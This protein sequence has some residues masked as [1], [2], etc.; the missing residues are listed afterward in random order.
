MLSADWAAALASVIDVATTNIENASLAVSTVLPIPP[1]HTSAVA[2]SSGALEKR[3]C[4]R[5]PAP[6]EGNRLIAVRDEDVPCAVS[7]IETG[8][9]WLPTK[10]KPMRQSPF[11]VHPRYLDFTLANMQASHRRDNLPQTDP[12]VDHL[13]IYFTRPSHLKSWSPRLLE[14][15][16]NASSS[17]STKLLYLGR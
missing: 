6:A 14:K 10:R 4:P 1:L 5:E 12:V 8:A 7:S 17:V 9:S 16:A 13:Y 2:I 11:M 15:N 3:V